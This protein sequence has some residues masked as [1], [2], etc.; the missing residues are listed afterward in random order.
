MRS[1][2]LD[3]GKDFLTEEGLDC[4]T[5]G[6]LEDCVDFKE[7][8]GTEGDGDNIRR[9]NKTE[10]TASCEKVIEI[11]SSKLLLSRIATSGAY[12]CQR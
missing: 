7:G 9:L 1:D 11:F 8:N 4:E 6:E 10:F 5:I 3:D 12:F 2:L